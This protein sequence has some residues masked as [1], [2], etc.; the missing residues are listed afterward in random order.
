MLVDIPTNQTMTNKCSGQQ[1]G[2]PQKNM[3]ID[4]SNKTNQ[5]IATKYTGQQSVPL[6]NGETTA[7]HN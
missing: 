4:N 6:Q 3:V 7:N 1:S 5:P 2:R